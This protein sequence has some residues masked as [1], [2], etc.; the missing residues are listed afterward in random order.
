VKKFA[1]ITGLSTGVIAMA[2]I[3]VLAA[4][5]LQ[6][7]T[8][9]PLFTLSPT[10]AAI[11]QCETFGGFSFQST[12]GAIS[13]YSISPTPPRG[14]S[15]NSVTGVLS[16]RPEVSGITYFTVS[17]TNSAGSYSRPFNLTVAEPTATVFTQLYP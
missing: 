7:S 11:S 15:F 2:M 10:S 9:A 12:G 17:G 1:S 5:P 14:M 4:Q 3:A 8:A 6:A 16:G 13:S